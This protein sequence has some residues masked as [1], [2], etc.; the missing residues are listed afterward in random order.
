[1][2]MGGQHLPP[3]KRAFTSTGRRSRRTRK[4]SPPTGIRSPAYRSCNY[5]VSGI[6]V[7]H[8]KRITLKPK[9]MIYKTHST[10]V[11]IN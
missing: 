7:N 1:M 2:G 10:K 8:G 6:P 3:G 4:I 9:R 11:R 5:T